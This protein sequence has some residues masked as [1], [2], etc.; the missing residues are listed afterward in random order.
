MHE[1]KRIQDIKNFQILDAIFLIILLYCTK[2]KNNNG[3]I[4]IYLNIFIF[5]Y[6]YLQNN[7]I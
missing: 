1:N 7:P 5:H 2:L 6:Y 4:S 3:F